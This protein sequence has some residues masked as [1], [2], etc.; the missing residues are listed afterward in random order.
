[1]CV[2][3][4]NNY[5]LY[6]FVQTTVFTSSCSKDSYNVKQ[7]FS[8]KNV[9]FVE[10]DTSTNKDWTQFMFLMANGRTSLPQVFINGKHIGGLDDIK[11]YYDNIIITIIIIVSL[12]CL[13]SR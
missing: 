6:C 5:F 8:K 3:H 4:I 11:R 13:E 10:I 1:M 12:K 9:P 7:L 2:A